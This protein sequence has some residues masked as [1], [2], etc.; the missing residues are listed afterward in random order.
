MQAL[1]GDNVTPPAEYCLI[2]FLKNNHGSDVQVEY[3]AEPILKMRRVSQTLGP[4]LG[5][6]IGPLEVMHT[7]CLRSSLEK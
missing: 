3:D 1:T 5:P 6:S 2:R 7:C 4:R